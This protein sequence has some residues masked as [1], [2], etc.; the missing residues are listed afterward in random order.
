MLLVI[1]KKI[2]KKQLQEVSKHFEGYVKVV[3]RRGR[4]RDK[5]D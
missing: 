1:D 4:S 2:T 5:S 3:G